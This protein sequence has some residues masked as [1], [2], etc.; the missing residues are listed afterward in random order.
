VIQHKDAHL[1]YGQK[2]EQTFN[3]SKQEAL[4]NNMYVFNRKKWIIMEGKLF[5]NG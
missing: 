5:L 4:F 2:P 1:K 3:G